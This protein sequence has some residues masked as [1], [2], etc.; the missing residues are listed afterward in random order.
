MS[1]TPAQ[2][3]LQAHSSEVAEHQYEV[4]DYEGTTQLTQGTAETHEDVSDAYMT[5]NNEDEFN[6]E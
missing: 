2:D 6:K 3:S 5:G 4:S 1:K